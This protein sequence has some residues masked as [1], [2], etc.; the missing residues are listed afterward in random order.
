MNILFVEI[1]NAGTGTDSSVGLFSGTLKWSSTGYGG[2]SSGII[3][4][5]TV[6]RVISAMNITRGG[7]FGGFQGT[8]S[9]G[10][11]SK[12]LV[13]AVI[14]KTISLIG[15]NLKIKIKISEDGNE[16]LYESQR[17]I[18]PI[19]SYRISNEGLVT[20]DCDTSKSFDRKKIGG[21]TV[22]KEM[23]FDDQEN[24]AIV[25]QKDLNL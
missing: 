10:A 17:F 6:S 4:Q 12:E 11:Y 15:K 25:F 9:V 20:I 8:V 13:A 2:Y 19:T 3:D 16:T 1:E 24:Q 14:S 21:I 23:A 7:G 5:K 22:T 18:C